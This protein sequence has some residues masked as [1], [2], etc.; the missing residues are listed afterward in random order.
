MVEQLIRNPSGGNHMASKLP[1][2]GGGWQRG[3]MPSQGQSGQG[4]GP[5]LWRGLAQDK[6]PG[7]EPEP[8][9]GSNKEEKFLE[10]A[11]ESPEAS[12]DIYE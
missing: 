7:P 3:P 4:Q 8:A 5:G 10:V 1:F 2:N 12:V 9:P 6:E 11:L